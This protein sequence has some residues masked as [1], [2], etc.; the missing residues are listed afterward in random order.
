MTNLTP[1]QQR[2]LQLARG[3]PG[4]AY[5]LEMGLGKTLLALTEFLGHARGDQQVTRLVVVC[6]NSFKAG[7]LAEIV[8]HGFK[9]DAHILQTSKIQKAYDWLDSQPFRSPPVLIVNYEAV[10]RNHVLD[11]IQEF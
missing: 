9:M 7:W 1:V 5:F 10:R 3:K 2:A 4:F 11:L 6:P 8:K